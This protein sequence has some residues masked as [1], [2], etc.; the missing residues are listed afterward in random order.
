MNYYNDK[1]K[2]KFLL[3]NEKIIILDKYSIQLF[4]TFFKFF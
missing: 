3:N 4:L 1:F 2:N